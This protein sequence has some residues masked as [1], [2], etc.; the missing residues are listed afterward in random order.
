[1]CFLHIESMNSLVEM[2]PF[3]I[4]EPK[5]H[6][7]DGTERED[8]LRRGR[9][10]DLVLMPGLGFDLSGGRLG[11]GGGYYDKFLDGAFNKAAQDGRDPPLLVALALR[12]QVIPCV[13]TEGHDRRID[14]LVTADG[15][16]DLR[17]PP[18]AE[19]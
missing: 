12:E 15:I 11:R 6:Y 4:L 2:P 1:M 18:P 10:L 16:H 7:S 9:P 19:G 14:I 5:P 17:E 13:P 8:A 3:G